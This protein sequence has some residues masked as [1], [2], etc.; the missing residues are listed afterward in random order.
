MVNDETVMRYLESGNTV[1]SM[2]EMKEMQPI[3]KDIH[4]VASSMQSTHDLFDVC[5][6]L[7]ALNLIVA[8]GLTEEHSK[9]NKCIST[10]KH[11]V[12]IR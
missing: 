9:R 3:L 11:I 8:T 10:A 7:S 4:R 12:S 6:K 5:V 2:D 1:L